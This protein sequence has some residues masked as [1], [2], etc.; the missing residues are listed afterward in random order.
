M[1]IQ[2]SNQIQDTIHNLYTL[3]KNSPD[4]HHQHIEVSQNLVNLYND[5][6]ISSP[7]Q[8]SL[9]D[10]SQFMISHFL[11]FDTNNARYLWKR[12]PSNLKEKEALTNTQLIELWEI[13]R[14]LT[15]QQYQNAFKLID[16]LVNSLQ[17]DSEQNGSML[18]LLE[19]LSTLLREHLIIMIRKAYATIEK[20]KLKALLGL[21]H[22]SQQQFGDYIAKK[23]MSLSLKDSGFVL[24][25][26]NQ[27]S[28]R[29]KKHFELNEDRVEQ[30][31]QVVQFL[32][33]QKYDFNNVN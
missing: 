2:S 7:G 3:V 20:G 33:Q 12:I 18:K 31:A 5:Y 24:P 29:N 28:A 9:S 13:G 4:D 17:Q 19:I 1:E 8:L 6:E 14:S 23:G 27:V 11:V 26:H 15:K 21:Q 25:G 10:Y 30:L 32:E 16:L 22:Y